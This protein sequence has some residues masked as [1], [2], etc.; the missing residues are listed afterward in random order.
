VIA[1]SKC[2]LK[3]HIHTGFYLPVHIR[4]C[5]VPVSSLEIK[6]TS[7]HIRP[8]YTK[9]KYCARSYLCFVLINLV[10]CSDVEQRLQNYPVC[11]LTGRIKTCMP[12][13]AMR[14]MKYHEI[15]T[16]CFDLTATA[17]S[18]IHDIKN[19]QRRQIVRN[20]R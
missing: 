8:R 10:S 7:L 17:R 1:N 16:S 5:T 18:L 2:L 9:V 6:Q 14:E 4:V 12:G 20:I 15:F 3:L 13:Y 19:S 11:G